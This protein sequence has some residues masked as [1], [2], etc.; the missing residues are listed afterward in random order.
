[1]ELNAITVTSFVINDLFMGYNIP[2]GSI[3]L[4]ELSKFHFINKKY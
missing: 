4:G 1:M 3:R 2:N